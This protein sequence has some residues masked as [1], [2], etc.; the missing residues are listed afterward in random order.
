MFKI[1]EVVEQVIREVNAA[2]KAGVPVE[3]PN[4]VRFE[5]DG[6]TFEIPIL[7]LMQQGEAWVD[8]SYDYFKKN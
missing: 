2:K 8:Y 6:I 7:R 3:L 5:K 1:R 4:V